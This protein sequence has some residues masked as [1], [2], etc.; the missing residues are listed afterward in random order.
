M[1][2]REAN[3]KER[4]VWRGQGG[5]AERQLLGCFLPMAQ[6]ASPMPR[7]LGTVQAN[8]CQGLSGGTLQGSVL[9]PVASSLPSQ[10]WM[11]TLSLSE[12]RRKQED[13]V[14]EEQVSKR[15]KACMVAHRR[16]GRQGWHRPMH[17]GLWRNKHQPITP[18]APLMPAVSGSS[19]AGS[20]CLWAI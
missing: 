4:W 6:C 10:L 13:Q 14:G 18:P 19:S 17:T 15:G 9:R 1:V 3:L 11:L 5:A 2:V 7:S 8:G 12:S 16:R 20:S